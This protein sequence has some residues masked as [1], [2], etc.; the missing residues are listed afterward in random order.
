MTI[1]G[2][3][4]VICQTI[5]PCPSRLWLVTLPLA[6]GHGPFL[7]AFVSHEKNLHIG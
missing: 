5:R 3:D 6:V 4:N 2:A 1:G 7:C